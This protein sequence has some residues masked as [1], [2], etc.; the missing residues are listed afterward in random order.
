VPTFISSP[1]TCRATTT[2]PPPSRPAP[3][4]HCLRCHASR[5]ATAL[6]HHA[7]HCPYCLPTLPTRPI[8][9]HQHSIPAHSPPPV[10]G[11]TWASWIRARSWQR[12]HARAC[13]TTSSGGRAGQPRVPLSATLT[14]SQGPPPHLPRTLPVPCRPPC[15]PHLPATSPTQARSLGGIIWLMAFLAHPWQHAFSAAHQPAMP[16]PLPDILPLFCTRLGTFFPSTFRLAAQLLRSANHLTTTPPLHATVPPLHQRMRTFCTPLL[17]CAPRHSLQL[18]C[19]CS[20]IYL[21][22]YGARVR[23][24]KRRRDK[25]RGVWCT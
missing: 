9:N 4:T 10:L 1:T 19:R 23:G 6:P 21:Y 16:P 17:H 3:L 20:P 8:T 22:P 5:L 15:A 12:T 13:G 25:R 14:S 7:L 11:V 2:H 18:V 24:C